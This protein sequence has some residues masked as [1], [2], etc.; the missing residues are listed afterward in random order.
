MQT[1]ANINVQILKKWVNFPL[2]I[3]LVKDLLQVESILE[4]LLVFTWFTRSYD[5][6]LA[7]TFLMRIFPLKLQITNYNL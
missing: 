7:K 2:F 3:S 4:L 1:I 5:V 6:V